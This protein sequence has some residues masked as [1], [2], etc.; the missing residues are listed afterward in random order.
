MRFIGRFIWLVITALTVVLSVAFATSNDSE[1]TLYL[2]P[3]EAGLTL[4]IWLSVLGALTAGMLIG[5]I[6]VWLSTIAIRTRAWRLQSKLRKMEARA[7]A[8]E[9]KL[10]EHDSGSSLVAT[11]NAN[12]F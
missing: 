3:L 9:N 5:G 12:Q 10:A 8:A 6:L 7:V 2:W 4:P 11:Q 1:M